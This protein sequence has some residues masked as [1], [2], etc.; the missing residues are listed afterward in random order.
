MQ[1]GLT[2]INNWGLIQKLLFRFF[3]AYFFIYIFPFPI[4]YI[5]FTDSLTTW[6]NSIWDA[7]VPWTGKYILHVSY[8]ITIKP[9]GSGDT[10]YNYVQLFLIA[11]FAIIAAIIWSLAD[12]RRKS[13]D[14][15]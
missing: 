11:V 5:P 8:P 2:A 10:T 4:G 15:L 3:A 6:Y 9:N 7:L 1:T 13:Y 12:R 14:L